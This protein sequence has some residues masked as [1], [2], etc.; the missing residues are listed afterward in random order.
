MH[1][2][3]STF[4]WIKFL[5]GLS[6][7]FI[8]I[9]FLF[10]LSKFL[11]ELSC[12]PLPVHCTGISKHKFALNTTVLISQETTINQ[13]Y[14]AKRFIEFSLKNT[15]IFILYYRGCALTIGANIC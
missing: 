7:F 14:Q 10:G 3:N 1:V 13:G 8:W 11:F 5:F 4:I 6:M 15:L 12:M 9:K 2:F